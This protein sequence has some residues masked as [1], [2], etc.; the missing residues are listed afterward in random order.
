MYSQGSWREKEITKLVS[1]GHELANHCKYDH[2]YHERAID[3]FE[4][5][6][7]ETNGFLS[8]LNGGNRTVRWFRAP[9]GKMTSAMSAVVKKKGL[10]HVMLDAY[11]NDC[12]IPD[13]SFIAATILRAV[14]DGSV[15]IIHFPE[16]GFREWNL[17]STRLVLEGLRAKGL[18]S[19]GLSEL[20]AAAMKKEN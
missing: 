20:G 7:D 3:E 10:K 9:S 14:S 11:S 16:R 5:D 18:R 2:E 19:V 17:E 8:K 4:R 12:H 6:L 15:V 13:P 1:R